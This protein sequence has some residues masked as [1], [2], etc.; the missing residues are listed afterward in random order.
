VR[1]LAI[2]GAAVLFSFALNSSLATANESEAGIERRLTTE[3]QS[4]WPGTKILLTTA[5]NWEDPSRL[6]EILASGAGQIQILNDQGQGEV[7]FAL[8]SS[9]TRVLGRATFSAFKSAWIPNR[10]VLPT[11]VLQ[12]GDF[13]LREVDVARSP[14]RE[15]RGILL[16]PSMKLEKL[17][18]RQ[19]LLEGAPVIVT[20]VQVQ[21]SVKRGASLRVEIVSGEIILSA[22]AQAMENAVT[23][24]NIRVMTDKQKRELVGKL[25][26]DGVVEVSL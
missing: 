9:E 14:L 11:E 22:Q 13:N 20:A 17:Q 5:I 24:G 2:A 26:E 21:P 15:T 23:G 12:V 10:R 6:A 4:R 19:T 25:R 7:R 8:V 16:E 1:S 3:L 18:A